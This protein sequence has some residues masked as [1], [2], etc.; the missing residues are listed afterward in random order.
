MTLLLT[1]S[2]CAHPA[3]LGHTTVCLDMFKLK[4]HITLAWGTKCGKGANNGTIHGPAGPIEVTES[5]TSGPGGPPAAAITGPGGPIMG[6]ES[7]HPVFDWEKKP[8]FK[9]KLTCA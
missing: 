4:I 3:F 2:I 9:P 1:H 6:G 5:A 7:A 8:T